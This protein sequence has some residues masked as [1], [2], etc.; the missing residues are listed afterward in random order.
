MAVD[1]YRILKDDGTWY[2]NCFVSQADKARDE[3]DTVLI[4]RYEFHFRLGR[5]EATIWFQ[6]SDNTDSAH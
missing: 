2:D 4:V 5:E 3:L 1:V 6:R